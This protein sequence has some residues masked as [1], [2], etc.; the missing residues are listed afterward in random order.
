MRTART[1]R[2]KKVIPILAAVLLAVVLT[3]CR[4]GRDTC[5]YAYFGDCAYAMIYSPE[6]SVMY[7]IDLPLEQILRWGKESGLDSIPMAMRNY[8]GLKDS[9][10]LLGS[11]DSLA[12]LRDVLDALG[13]EDE[14]LP[15]GKKR[16]GT[17][18]A[19]AAV[20]N[21]KPLSDRIIQL[22]GQ[23]AESL[24]KLLSE[25]KPQC[26]CYDAHSMFNSDD[27]NFSQRYFTQWLE[28]VLGGNT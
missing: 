18:V 15:S 4:A 3:G 13:S 26:V 1:S 27:L 2:I 16:V 23:D 21:T 7:F 24:M 14:S 20:L 5:Y 6:E 22:C 19:K 11:T 17:L 28:Q 25:K 12:V 10:F 9:G 8:V